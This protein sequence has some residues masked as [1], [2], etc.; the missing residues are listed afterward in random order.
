MILGRLSL[1][2]ILDAVL[3]LARNLGALLNAVS[4]LARSLLKLADTIRSFAWRLNNDLGTASALARYI[5]KHLDLVVSQVLGSALLSVRLDHRSHVIVAG[6]VHRLTGPIESSKLSQVLCGALLASM[7]DNLLL[8]FK[9]FFLS[10]VI[11][12]GGGFASSVVLA[13]TLFRD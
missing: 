4:T 13:V 9:F 6:Q 7:L 12:F 10:G 3:A 5:L 1:A 11:L 2:R 8:L